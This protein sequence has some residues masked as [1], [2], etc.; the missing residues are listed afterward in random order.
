[1]DLPLHHCKGLLHR[2]ILY[3]AQG[4]LELDSKVRQMQR[5][6]QKLHPFYAPSVVIMLP[7]SIMEFEPVKVA[8]VSLK[9]LCRKM[10]NMFV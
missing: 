10:P 6:Q 4:H 1:M 9:E 8:R 3:L 2:T 7:V 5:P